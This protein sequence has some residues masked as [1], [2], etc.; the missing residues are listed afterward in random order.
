MSVNVKADPTRPYKTY[1]AIVS[2]FLSSFLL[3]SATDLP[4]WA[5][6]LLTAAVAAISVYVTA[7]P[8]VQTVPPDGDPLEGDVLDD[9][10]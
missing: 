10:R 1:A 8:V 5:V 3:T 6:G 2:A 7:N 4:S 9:P